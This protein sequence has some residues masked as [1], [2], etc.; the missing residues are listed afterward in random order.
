MSTMRRWQFARTGI[1][2]PNPELPNEECPFRDDRLVSASSAVADPE[3]Y[4]SDRRGTATNFGGRGLFP[5]FLRKP[6]DIRSNLHPILPADQ[7][8][9]DS[10]RQVFKSIG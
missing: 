2:L 8:N 10:R 4:A 9:Y 6:D 7:W 1:L 3:S 5:L